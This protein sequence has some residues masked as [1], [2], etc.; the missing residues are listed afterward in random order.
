MRFMTSVASIGGICSDED[1]GDGQMEFRTR[2]CSKQGKTGADI[3]QGKIIA[4]LENI[5]E[6]N[7]VADRVVAYAPNL[8]LHYSVT[9]RLWKDD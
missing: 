5:I 7:E 1:S 9:M 3:L 8:N 6:V 4:C 2:C